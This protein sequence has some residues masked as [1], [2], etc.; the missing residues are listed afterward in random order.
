MIASLRTALGQP[1]LEQIAGALR[2]FA[3][4]C[5]RQ[6]APRA[7]SSLLELAEWFALGD[8]TPEEAE[9]LRRANGPLASVAATTGLADPAT[10]ADA[11]AFLAA[12]HALGADACDAA[13][14]ASAVVARFGAANEADA[15]L[16]RR[17]QADRLRELLGNPL[18]GL[19]ASP[20]GGDA[21]AASPAASAS[22]LRQW[23]DE[24][25]HDAAATAVLRQ[26]R[27]FREEL[28][29][30]DA[31]I[32]VPGG[33]C[34]IAFGHGERVLPIGALVHLWGHWPAASGECPRCGGTVL[35]LHFGGG[36]SQ[37]GV[38][39]YCVVCERRL[40]RPMGGVVAIADAVRPVLA[41]TPYFVAGLVNPMAIPHVP[42]EP[43]EEAVRAV[44]M[45]R[46]LNGCPP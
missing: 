20:A 23:H 16:V 17:E 40:L 5:A 4:W 9:M 14:Q 11:A 13:L 34:T 8:F 2:Q 31:W 1:A 43:F 33:R 15:A 39:G 30:V 28:L 6:R 38:R 3:C 32:P 18:A 35:A 24:G 26:L 29:A 46:M 21:T 12:F 42:A 19:D 45:Q 44:S 22:A 10:R 27:A 25:T 41:E 37:G 36:P 7:G